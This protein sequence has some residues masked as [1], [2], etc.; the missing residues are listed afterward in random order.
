[1]RRLFILLLLV[2]WMTTPA[3]VS[4]QEGGATPV[5]GFAPT[6]PAE[7][8]TPEPFVPALLITSPTA[9]ETLRGSLPIRINATLPGIN[10]WELSFAFVDNPTDTWF[11]LARGNEPFSGDIIP[12]DTTL[13]T[14]GDYALRLRGFFAEA[15][16]DVIIQPLKIRNYTSDTPTPAASP[17]PENTSTATAIITLV[18]VTPTHTASPNAPARL[19]P[20][21]LPPNPAIL[22]NE[23]IAE[24]ALRGAGYSLLA[25]GVIGFLAWARRKLTR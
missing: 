24:S 11:L 1:M 20:T 4:A 10:A 2:L 19:S 14:D 17:T 3:P 8:N 18:T 21:P 25:F 12:W 15:Y 16:R 9:E 22:R 7:T 5:P 23:Q 13:L 6:S